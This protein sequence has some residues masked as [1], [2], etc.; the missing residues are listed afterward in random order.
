M[1]DSAKARL[2]AGQPPTDEIEV[3]WAS[4][5]RQ[6]EILQ[7]LRRQREEV[8]PR[9]KHSGPSECGQNNTITEHSGFC[10]LCSYLL[11]MIEVC[12]MAWSF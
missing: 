1:L 8:S 12:Q 5:V 4:K 2:A 6:E 11:Q 3:E 9:Q 7:E 10:N